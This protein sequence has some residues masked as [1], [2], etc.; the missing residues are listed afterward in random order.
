MRNACRRGVEA[1]LADAL[2]APHAVT[3][4]HQRSAEVEVTSAVNRSRVLLMLHNDLYTVC[5]R[6]KNPCDDTI[7]GC[8]HSIAGSCRT[9]VYTVVRSPAFQAIAV[10]R[11]VDATS[12]SICGE[13]VGSRTAKEIAGQ[14]ERNTSQA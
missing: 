13:H 11:A 1:Y 14:S 3:A 6:L 4:T 10:S 7:R 2:A 8:N 12:V 5:V 9:E